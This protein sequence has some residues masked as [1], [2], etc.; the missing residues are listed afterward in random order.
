MM[1]KIT[2]LSFVLGLALLLLLVACGRTAPIAAEPPQAPAL[3]G[4]GELEFTALGTADFNATA[5]FYGDELNPQELAPWSPTFFVPFEVIARSSLDYEGFRYVSITLVLHNI[6]ELG[7]GTLHNLTLLPVSYDGTLGMTP[8]TR[9]ERFDGSPF[10]GSLGDI[11]PSHGMRLVGRHLYVD[12]DKADFVAYREDEVPAPINPAIETIFPYGWVAQ[13]VIEE[14]HWWGDIRSIEP[15]QRGLITA[16]FKLPL[17]SPTEDLF[18]FRV[19]IVMTQDSSA[20]VTQSP[21]ENSDNGFL[22]VLERARHNWADTVVAIGTGVRRFEWQWQELNYIGLENVRITGT[23]DN[24]EAFLL[25]HEQAGMPTFIPSHLHVNANTGD[26][27]NIGTHSSPL[28][29]ISRALELVLEGDS[30]T[31]ALGIY[32][33]NLSIT[34]S[35][36]L[37]G[38]WDGTGARAIIRPTEL[39][40]T[41]AII[42]IGDATGAASVKPYAN[43]SN[44]CYRRLPYCSVHHCGFPCL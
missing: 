43:I 8:F 21:E 16:A 42:D 6:P 39:S 35:L 3:L 27:S 5:R 33:E 32:A 20:R 37:R 26:D 18:N 44:P 30:I 15:G 22:R 25:P 23:R 40:A 38:E 36:T 14:D 29:T 13:R 28:K 7:F 41:G 4:V 11:K 34:K 31:V 1:A 24:P 2:K 9:A 12:D 17:V 19:A 10:T